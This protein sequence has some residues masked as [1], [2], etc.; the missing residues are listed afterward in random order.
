[1]Q[2]LSDETLNEY[3]DR[4]LA[5]D[6]HTETEAH[7]A[8]CPDCAA[9]L[10]NLRA[11]FAELDALPDLPLE[12]DIA[13][14]I[15]TRLEQNTPLPRPLRWLTIVQAL[16]VLLAGVLFGPLAETFIQGIHLPLSSAFFAEQ[17]ASWLQTIANWRIPPIMIELPSLNLDLSSTALILTILSISLL[18]LSANGLLLIPR[19]RRNS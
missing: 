7:L 1:M 3:L 2:H 17:S 12:A 16:G 9:R 18:W 14:A 10:V 11:L 4:A 13:P 15:L 6:L 5:P 19:S 8:A